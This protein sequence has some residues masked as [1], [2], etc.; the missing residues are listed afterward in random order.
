MAN[1]PKGPLRERMSGPKGPLFELPSGSGAPLKEP[2]TKPIP[3]SLE[4]GEASSSPDITEPKTL[5]D[6]VFAGLDSIVRRLWIGFGV[7]VLLLALAGIIG[8]RSL[9]VMAGQIDATL[10]EV[11]DEA[12]LSSQL[13]STVAQQLEA[14]N[15]YLTSPDSIANAEFRDLGTQAHRIRR[16]MNEIAVKTADEVRLIAAVDT[17]MSQMEIHYALAHRLTDLGRA[18]EARAEAARARPLVD[19][20]LRDI[21][22]LGA[23]KSRKLSDAADR[24]TTFTQTRVALLAGLITLALLIAGAVVTVTVRSISRPL[25]ALVAHAQKLSEGDLTVR[26]SQAMPGEFRILAD[27]M[28]RTGVSLSRVVAVAARTS[29]EVS[30]SAEDLAS[31]STEVAQAVSQTATAM[32]EVSEGAES[33]VRELQSMDATVSD[34]ATRART[35]VKDANEVELLASGIAESSAAKRDEIDRALGMLVSVKSSVEQATEEV[36]ALNDSAA[37]INRFVGT[38]SRIAEQTN[39]LAL[40]AAIEA[41]RAGQAGRGFAVVAEEVR[42]LAEQAQQ[43]ADEIVV[44]TTVVTDRVTRTSQTMTAG[45]SRVGEVEQLSREI[46]SALSAITDSA[47]RTRGAAA[48]LTDAAEANAEALGRVTGGIATI[49]KTAEQHAASAQEV[50]A[51]TEEQ[52]AACQE[53]TS[54]SSMLL[55]SAMQL[56]DL[57]RGLRT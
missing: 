51:S 17:R 55:K 48:S 33:Q 34:A 6:R 20:L 10:K 19:A 8:W 35:M 52:S 1:D 25:V 31:V 13:S 36:V 44:L 12:T 26:T 21:E 16:Q 28:N 11:Q 3:E 24:L 47:E 2:T 53:M 39:L 50:S 43:A 23:I 32:S 40:N 29:D 37:A 49:A 22:R 42:K 56:R 18:N 14:A 46:D 38:V 45:V 54:A 9:S 4:L 41:A 57:V 5:G 7:L 15:H 27:A 30:R